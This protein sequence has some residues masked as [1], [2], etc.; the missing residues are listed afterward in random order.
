MD[1]DSIKNQDNPALIY[2]VPAV[3]LGVMLKVL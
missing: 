2:V 3:F 1:M